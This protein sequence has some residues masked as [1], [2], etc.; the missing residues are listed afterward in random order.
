VTRYLQGGWYDRKRRVRL[1]TEVIDAAIDVAGMLHRA[2]VPAQRVMRIALKARSLVVLT[3]PLSSGTNRFS[4]R[5][6][7]AMKQQL[8]NYSDGYPELQ[9]FLADCLDHVADAN[10]M[11]GLYLHLIHIARMMQLLTHALDGAAMLQG[12]PASQAHRAR[13]DAALETLRRDPK[14]KRRPK[15]RRSAA[16]KSRR[17]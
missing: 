15:K 1:R 11:T 8:G 9:S 7:E 17:R 14:A 2:S 3:N 10:D 13:A 5:D 6:R 12:S 4:D 16:K